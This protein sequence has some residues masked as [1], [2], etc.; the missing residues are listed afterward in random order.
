MPF[1][2]QTIFEQKGADALP[3]QPLSN[4]AAFLVENQLRVGSAGQNE[5]CCP[6]GVRWQEWSQGRDAD[7]RDRETSAGVLVGDFFEL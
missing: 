1:D 3:A 6:V 4:L 7:S 2:R 5:Y